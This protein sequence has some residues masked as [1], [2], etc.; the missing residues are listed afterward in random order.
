ML[1]LL[2]YPRESWHV[3]LN[4]AD[5][6]VGLDVEDVERTLRCPISAQVPS[7]RAVAASINKGVPLVLDEPGHPVSVAIRQLAERAIR[8]EQV[9][10]QPTG[11]RAERGSR[12]MALLRRGRS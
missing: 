9:P 5:A 3:V 8:G 7:S 12:R 4:R 6:K 10:A 2:G 11:R 1:D